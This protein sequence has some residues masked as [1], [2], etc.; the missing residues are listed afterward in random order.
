MHKRPKP[1]PRRRQ[2]IVTN[3][4][5]NDFFCTHWG[6]GRE[7]TGEDK[8]RPQKDFIYMFMNIGSTYLP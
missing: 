8:Q 2:K 7:Q 5:S 6:E 1:Q 3:I 4:L